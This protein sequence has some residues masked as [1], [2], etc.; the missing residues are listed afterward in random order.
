MHKK[1]DNKCPGSVRTSAVRITDRYENKKEGGGDDRT[2][3]LN[4]DVKFW[5][6]DS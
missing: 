4:T 6:A 5:C 3:E 2:K 1:V